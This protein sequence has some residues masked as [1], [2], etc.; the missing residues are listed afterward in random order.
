MSYNLKNKIVVLFAVSF[1]FSVALVSNVSA[2]EEQN[3]AITPPVMAESLPN[4]DNTPTP[5]IADDPFG[6]DGTSTTSETEMPDFGADLLSAP[7]DN[8]LRMPDI[9]ENED[10]KADSDIPSLDSMGM[11]DVGLDTTIPDISSDMGLSDVSIDTPATKSPFEKYGNAIL[12]RVDNDLFNQ[13]SEIEKQTTLLNL[14]LK[15]EE[16]RNRIDALKA[17]RERAKQEELDHEAERERKARD[18]EV[19]RQKALLQEQMKLKEKEV[20]VEKIRQAKI[21]SEYMN[22]ALITNQQWVDI[23]TKLAMQI[24]E[25]QE[26]R[27]KMILDF[28]KTLEKINQ[29][30]HLT[31]STAEDTRVAFERKLSAL[32]KQIAGLK[33]VVN[34]K[35]SALQDM[36]QANANADNPFAEDEISE[37]AVDMSKDYAIMEITG[38]GSNIVAKMVGQDGTTFTVRKGSVL[39]GGEVVKNIT[40]KVITFENM[41][42]KSYLYTN[43][44]VMQYEPTDTF[45]DSSKTPTTAQSINNGQ[46]RKEFRKVNKDQDTSNENP[47]PEV[48]NAAP[49]PAAPANRPMI[50]KTHSV[51]TSGGSAKPASTGGIVSFSKGMMM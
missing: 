33:Q 5:E 12:S 18:E 39:K 42:K 14:E 23:N 48:Q 34:E 2:E 41:G 25:L 28:E 13:M 15:R 19:S 43:A 32:N 49:A 24:H 9:R 35:D 4:S 20:E 36:V 1:S 3:A 47:Q 46:F 10:K 17:Q 38:K 11:P 51:S 8:N 6:M 26:E 45:N 50:R 29:K 22:N 21:L 44:A 31:I 27:K 30:T 40:D 37:D 16:V 7:D